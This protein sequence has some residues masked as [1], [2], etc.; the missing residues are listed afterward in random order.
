MMMDTVGSSAMFDLPAVASNIF[1]AVEAVNVFGTG[2]FS[3]QV[4]SEICKFLFV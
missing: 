4:E 2:G 3:S 1:A